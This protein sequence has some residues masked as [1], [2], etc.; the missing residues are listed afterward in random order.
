LNA[1][2]RCNFVPEGNCSFDEG[3]ISCHSRYC[4]VRQYN[5]DKPAKF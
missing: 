3:G 5:K 2:A 1:G 4:P